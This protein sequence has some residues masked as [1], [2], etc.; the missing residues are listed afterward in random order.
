M[1]VKIGLVG[2]GPVC[3]EIIKCLH[4]INFPIYGQI[5]RAVNQSTK[6]N[7]NDKGDEIF[8]LNQL[9]PES[10]LEYFKDLNL[11][12]FADQEGPNGASVLWA[13]R[14]IKAYSCFCI[15]SGSD[16]RL[17]PCVPLVVPEVNIDKVTN[18]TK[19]ISSPN[20]V[21]TPMTVIL[22]PLHLAAR[23]K[24]IIVSTYQS[25]SGW[26]E[27]ANKQLLEELKQLVKDNRIKK[28]NPRIFPKPIALDCIPHIGRFLPN[29][30]TKEEEKIVNET[31]K[32]MDMPNL[33]ISAT[34]VRVPVR[35]GHS[36]SINIE[37]NHPLKA[38]KAKEILCDPLLSPGVTVIDGKT[39]DPNAAILRKDSDELQY[40]TQA[41]I[42]KDRW[43]DLVLVGR[44]RDDKTVKYGLNLWCVSNN[45]RK[46]AATNVVQIAQN[47]FKRGIIC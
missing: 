27:A 26:G 33:Q 14:A 45:M 5:R 36:M 43:K 20:C 34:A 4:E 37:F 28:F 13:R 22:W 1:S 16:F 29:S 11:V 12:F 19:L 39:Q 31:R 44:I 40:P 21:V 15:D 6:E 38:K 7:L 24:R 2:T 18:K 32:I 3:T 17:D 46:G 42:L 41:D 30:Y 47:M 8:L 35:V 23:I 10:S 9:E 25:V